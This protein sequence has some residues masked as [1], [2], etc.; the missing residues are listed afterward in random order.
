MGSKNMPWFRLY[1]E[2]ASDVKF[3]VIAN[4]LQYNRPFVIGLWVLILCIAS[5]SPIRGKL[6]AHSDFPLTDEEL[7]LILDMSDDIGY[8]LEILV[9]LGMLIVDEHGAYCISN[10]D[11]RQ[12]INNS[13]ERSRKHRD[14]ID[15]TEMQR[16]CNV[17]LCI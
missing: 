13:T 6:Y 9:K 15:A 7:G 1:T 14:D 8:L 3:A 10:W 16:K 12:Y 17:L 4:R 11:E 5:D 2:L